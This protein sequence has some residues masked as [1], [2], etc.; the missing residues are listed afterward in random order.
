M[1]WLILR[2]KNPGTTERHLK[3]IGIERVREAL[4][5]LKREKAKIIGLKPKKR[6]RPESVS[7]K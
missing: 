2:H 5:D 4:E 3:S 1:G 7:K 6:G